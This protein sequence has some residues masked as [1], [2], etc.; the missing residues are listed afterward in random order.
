[1]AEHEGIIARLNPIAQDAAK[2]DSRTRKEVFDARLS[3]SAKLLAQPSTDPSDPLNEPQVQR[4]DNLSPQTDDMDTSA[5]TVP[6][7]RDSFPGD[8]ETSTGDAWA[9]DSSQ[10]SIG[11]LPSSF[12]TPYE[13]ESLNYSPT[14]T[15]IDQ[16]YMQNAHCLSIEMGT[17]FDWFTCFPNQSP[18]TAGTVA[19]SCLNDSYQ[20]PD[21]THET[22]NPLAP[23]HTFDLWNNLNPIG[24]FGSL[25]NTT[26]IP[27]S[28][29]DSLA[30]DLFNSTHN[31][32]YLDYLVPISQY[33]S[34][35]TIDQ[36]DSGNDHLNS[37]I[38]R[39]VAH[40]DIDPCIF[41]EPVGTG[42][43]LRSEELSTPCTFQ[44]PAFQGSVTA[45]TC[46]ATNTHDTVPAFVELGESFDCELPWDQ[47][48]GLCGE[49]KATSVVSLP[50]RLESGKVVK[51]I[52][53]K[54]ALSPEERRRIAETRRM[55]ACYLCNRDR[56][57]VGLVNFNRVWIS[58]DQLL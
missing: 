36:S 35:S 44:R 38:T 39:P 25:A 33:L 18:N 6:P 32:F 28:M 34:P 24:L 42:R 17:P 19:H 40:L 23:H 3:C 16:Q 54:K 27:N 12:V 49:L 55:G 14:S 53:K 22:Y 10:Q 4:I 51:A 43:F 9:A 46:L 29:T 48:Q 26:T 11:N 31:P 50:G 41:Q 57:K 20:M 8:H 37:S 47:Q 1:M 15:I 13:P 45:E 52:R 58:S 30:I 56:S 2:L 5:I 21:L 7:V